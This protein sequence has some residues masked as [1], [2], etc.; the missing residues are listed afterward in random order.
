MVDRS[1]RDDV[2]WY[3]NENVTLTYTNLSN[4]TII[5]TH[6]VSS[7]SSGRFSVDNQIHCAHYSNTKTEAIGLYSGRAA[8][9]TGVMGSPC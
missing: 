7:D 6:I 2:W 8:V 3:S 1:I 4:P 5:R 9:F